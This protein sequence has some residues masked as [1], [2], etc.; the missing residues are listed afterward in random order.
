MKILHIISQRPDSTGSGIYLQEII[1]QAVRSGHQNF[2]VCGIKD[3]DPLMPTDIE[4]KHI[5]PVLFET[6]TNPGR[7][8]GM[9]DVM[10]YSSRT[11]RSLDSEAVNEYLD[12]FNQKITSAV[13]RFQPDLI[14]THH[15]WLV[16]SLV[17]ERYQHLPVITSCH[18]SELRQFQ[19]CPL[20]RAPVLAG[21]RK[22]KKILALT[23]IQKRE[24]VETY[25]VDP[26]T[27]S[28]V[29]AGIN[30]SIFKPKRP[31]TD[32]KCNPPQLLYA[33]KLSRAKGVLWLLRAIQELKG[34]DL[35]LH[36][37][38]SGS[39]AEYQQCVEQAEKV[40][41]RV[42]FYGALS[43]HRLSDL[44]RDSDIFILPSLYEGLP[45]VVLEALACGCRVIATDLPGTREI[46][47]RIKSER[48]N[49][50]KTPQV[51]NMDKT[52]I[53]NERGFIST[54]TD[55]L[56]PHLTSASVALSDEP[57]L[58]YYTWEAVYKRIHTTW[59]NCP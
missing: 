47:N 17:A 16:S 44:M 54:L 11:F 15:L 41:N 42:S 43:Q 39:G 10:P 22:L 52:V 30:T 31:T 57:D 48:L 53:D 20:L 56:L 34:F 7:I 49:L 33:G 28:V 25:G 5:A 59:Q 35:H 38:G 2:L 58:S 29:G 36:I 12:V 9:S 8:I 6:T 32:L 26:E 24:I 18:G 23:Q 14:H 45:L 27:I 37:A 21:C 40:K 3:G 1:S 50:I 4:P 13:N 19:Q 51:L 46:S 55:A